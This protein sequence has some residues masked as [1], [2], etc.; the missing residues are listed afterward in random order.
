[1]T[2]AGGGEHL[3]D[4]SPPPSPIGGR[5]KTCQQSRPPPHSTLP[6]IQKNA[7]LKCV[8]LRKYLDDFLF[9]KG[10]GTSMT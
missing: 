2:A 9:K 5:F 6:Q 3:N 4:K 10:L 8:F 7:K 1:M